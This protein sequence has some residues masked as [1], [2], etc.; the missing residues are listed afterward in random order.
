MKK[1][2]KVFVFVLAT[3]LLASILGACT[4][5]TGD[6]PAGETPAAEA[7]AAEAPAAEGG[8]WTCPVTSDGSVDWAALGLAPVEINNVDTFPV[9]AAAPDG[10]NFKSQMEVMDMLTPQDLEAIYNGGHTAYIVMHFMNA[11]W[12][13]LQVA[14]MTAVCEALNIQILGVGDG[15]AKADEQVSIIESAIGQNPDIL[16]IK[17]VDDDA[18]V[19]IETKAADQGIVV[20][21]IDTANLDLIESGKVISMIQADN[22]TFSQLCAE[23][24]VERL[25]EEGEVLMLNYINPLWHT[26]LR[27]QAAQDTFAKYPNV[28]IV[29]EMKMGTPEEAADITES[30]ISAH[31]NLGAIWAAWN[32]PATA[33]GSVAVNLGKTDIIASGPGISTDSAYM[34]ATNGPFIGGCADFAYDMGV[35]NAL[36]GIAG[37]LGKDVPKYVAVPVVAYTR[38]NLADVWERVFHEPLDATTLEALESN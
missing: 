20:V 4:G 24:I 29:S 37:V 28:D 11:S 2:K 18:L 34:M 9:N 15:Q 36:V 27:T 6:A 19:D 10:G 33:A 38:D 3:V 35:T 16:M 12:S 31:P 22:Y 8:G 13:Q 1:F 5:N 7:P 21:G 30:V 25:N 14:G 32:D 23:A 17:S 26:N